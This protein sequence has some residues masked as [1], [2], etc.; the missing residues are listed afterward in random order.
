MGRVNETRTR[1]GCPFSFIVLGVSISL[2]PRV[3]VS[4]G[5]TIMPLD[6]DPIRKDEAVT[7]PKEPRRLTALHLGGSAER[8][9]G[10]IVVSVFHGRAPKARRE[11]FMA[12]GTSLGRPSQIPEGHLKL[13]PRPWWSLST[14]RPASGCHLLVSGSG[15]PEPL[16]RALVG[17]PLLEPV[18]QNGVLTTAIGGDSAFAPLVMRSCRLVVESIFTDLLHIT[19]SFSRAFRFHCSHSFLPH[20]YRSWEAPPIA[21][22][23]NQMTSLRMQLKRFWLCRPYM[24]SLRRHLPGFI[25]AL[26]GRMRSLPTGLQFR[27]TRP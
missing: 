14:C 20:H 9:S 3:S 1:T 26:Y 12:T 10:I 6:G 18:D 22:S 11:T 19:E 8:C 24:P 25:S 17:S 23:L 16:S 15:L 27:S 5:M 13:V 4:H 2:M 21:Q 7:N